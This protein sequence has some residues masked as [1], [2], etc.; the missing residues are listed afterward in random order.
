MSS[1]SNAAR[2]FDE[3]KVSSS[4]EEW[5]D[6]VLALFQE[7]GVE[8]YRVS[9][10]SNEVL[11]KSSDGLFFKFSFR[12]GNLT[13]LLKRRFISVTCHQRLKGGGFIGSDLIW[14]LKDVR[15]G[16][17]C[18]WTSD[19]IKNPSSGLIN[20]DKILW[21]E[22]LRSFLVDFRRELGC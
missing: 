6:D 7:C 19:T 10:E 21:L 14:P 4:T 5:F 22:N 13:G 18:T 2:S 1:R 12:G 17:S 8:V 3:T 16:L 15:H 9:E 11:I 20:F